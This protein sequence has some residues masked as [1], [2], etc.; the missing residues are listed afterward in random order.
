MTLLIVGLILF[1]GSHST[2]IINVGWRDATAARLGEWPWKGLYSSVAL[3]GF[4][5]IVIGYG[6]A[7]LEAP[8]LYTLPLWLRH[9]ALVLLLPVFPL[10]VSTYVPGRISR[11]AKH[12]TLLATKLWATAHLL[13]NG[14]MADVLLFGAF[15]AWAVADR[16][17][18]KRR[19][20]RPLPGAPP[21]AFNDV[22]AV[23]VGVAIYA[24]FIMGVHQWLFG[25][26]AAPM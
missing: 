4:V 18:M 9:L 12:P 5:L 15:L 17:S 8:V 25:V 6:S 10:F 7:R 20:Q 3:A 14:T 13:V 2:S 11:T 23:T 19:D 24:A 1:L 16:I 26:S 21:S 22:I